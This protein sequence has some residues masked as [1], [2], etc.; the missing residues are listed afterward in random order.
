MMINIMMMIIVILM[1]IIIIIRHRR[2][3]ISDLVDRGDA[4]AWR[5]ERV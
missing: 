5:G 4:S 3:L 2:A 1:I